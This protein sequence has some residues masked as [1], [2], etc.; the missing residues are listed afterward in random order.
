MNTVSHANLMCFFFF[1]CY[2]FAPYM[3]YTSSPITQ[4]RTP[5][6]S[7]SL[8]LSAPIEPLCDLRWPGSVKKQRTKESRHLKKCALNV[9][10]AALATPLVDWSLE[11]RNSQCGQ[12]RLLHILAVYTSTTKKKTL[13]FFECFSVHHLVTVDPLLGFIS[14]CIR[15]CGYARLG[16]A[17]R[18]TKD[19][20]GSFLSN[21]IWQLNFFL[22]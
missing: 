20:S 19:C 18:H 5:S 9:L 6:L 10:V 22:F 13:V 2:Y 17:A 16:S 11:I 7:L 1:F 14:Y 4:K 3:A 8:S 15:Q 21:K 12:L